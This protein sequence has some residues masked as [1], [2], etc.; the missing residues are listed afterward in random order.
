VQVRTLVRDD[1]QLRVVRGFLHVL[2]RAAPG[3]RALVVAPASHRFMTRRPASSL[4]RFFIR[5][6]NTLF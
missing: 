6:K 1:Q 4:H 3:A 2:L 5:N